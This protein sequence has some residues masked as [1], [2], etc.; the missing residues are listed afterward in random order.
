[1]PGRRR[2]P[3]PA[4]RASVGR[5][6]A[7]CPVTAGER[8]GRILPG[9]PGPGPEHRRFPRLRHIGE[10]KTGTTFLQDVLWGNQSWLAARGVVL[11]GYS[12]RDHSAPPGPA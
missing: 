1:M 2:A 9:R 11:P 8:P 12:H 10:P 3:M 6:R 4:S 5:A 7:G